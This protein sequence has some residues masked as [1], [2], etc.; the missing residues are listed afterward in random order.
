MIDTVS[1]LLPDCET[2][3]ASGVL[4]TDYFS[5][6]Y[7]AESR[8]LFKVSVEGTKDGDRVRTA[9]VVL[10]VVPVLDNDYNEQALAVV[11]PDADGV[12]RL[13]NQVG[14]IPNGRCSTLQPR[15]VSLMRATNGY[16]GARGTASYWRGE[17]G[18]DKSNANLRIRIAQWEGVHKAALGILRVIEPDVEQPWTGHY[19]PLT[20]LA[21]RLYEQGHGRSEADLLRVR[22]EIRD[23]DLV[24]T[25][26]GEVVTNMTQGGRDFFDPLRARVEAQGAV[27]GWVRLYKGAV[28]VRSEDRPPLGESA[29]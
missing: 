7:R 29:L 10:A 14:W 18:W 23:D 21:R 17:Q 28:E 1:M 6:R 27:R 25:A 15:V 8:R 11:V 5:K 12:V 22:Y 19:A 20:D 2:R 16:V 3:Y 24:A 13:E 4:G 26:N 9:E